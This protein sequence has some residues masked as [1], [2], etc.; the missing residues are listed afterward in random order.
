M[1]NTLHLVSAPDALQLW[2]VFAP[3][4]AQRF[5]SSHFARDLEGLDIELV[6]RQ[7][8]QLLSEKP[9]TITQLGAALQ[10]RWPDR[11]AESLAYSLRH[12][13]PVVQVP[14]RAVWGKRGAATWS[15]ATAWLGKPLNKKISLETVVLRY[16]A[17][18]GP[19]SVSDV[20]AWSGLAG[21]RPV[22]ERLR[23]QL[24]TFR[25]ERGRELFDLPD[26]PRP[27]AR[28]SVPPRFLPEY[29]N[30]VL[31]HQ[32]RTRVIALEH[33]YLVA[34]GTFLVDGFVAGSWSLRQKQETPGLTISSFQSLR[35]ADRAALG[36]EGERL[37][38][39][40]AP[41]AGRSVVDFVVA[42]PRSA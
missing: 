5:Q 16:L 29:D 41:K 25:D 11:P 15:L 14:P 18:F 33:R 8:S 39:F 27:D 22:V 23:P 9:R 3:M 24:Q 34:S 21:L 6:L 2:P 30:I 35:R 7:A 12:L 36:E 26:G 17:A 19:A 28:T 4:L 42:P 32:D 37:L 38:Q 20:A 10:S 40:A 1:R 13:A 31:G